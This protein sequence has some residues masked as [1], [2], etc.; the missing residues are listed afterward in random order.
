MAGGRSPKLLELINH[1]E[2][3]IYNTNAPKQGVEQEVV[4]RF[5]FPEAA[6]ALDRFLSTLGKR[7]FICDINTV[8]RD[9][10]I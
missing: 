1:S 9:Y 3:S 8:D 10:N 6:G 7:R 2:K 4:Y 5:E